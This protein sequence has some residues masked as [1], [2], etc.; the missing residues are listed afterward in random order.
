MKL[1]SIICALLLLIA[2]SSAST[3]GLICAYGE[4]SYTRD[5]ICSCIP[6]YSCHDI[7]LNQYSVRTWTDSVTGQTFTQFNVEIINHLVVNVKNIVIGSDASLCLRD[8]SSIWN[9]QLLS[10]GNLILPSVQPSINKDNSYTFGFILKGTH[11]ANLYI[12]AVVY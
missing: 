2:V 6:W 1:L 7:S 12:K 10:N 8:S 9:M 5:S 3:N 11:K 4:I